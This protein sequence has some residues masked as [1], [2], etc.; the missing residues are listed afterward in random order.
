MTEKARYLGNNYV[1]AP[2]G[3]DCGLSKRE[4]FAAVA[5]VGCIMHG[6]ITPENAAIWSIKCADALLEELCKD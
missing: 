1:T 5:M 3:Y 2:E 6:K 4:Y